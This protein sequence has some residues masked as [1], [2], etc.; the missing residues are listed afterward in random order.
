MVR[1]FAS[2]RSI[3][4]AKSIFVGNLPEYTTRHEVET[5]FQEYGSIVQTNIIKKSFSK[6]SSKL[7][8]LFFCA[9][10]NAESQ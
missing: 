4:D 7:L 2:P 3:M 5:L 6:S 10:T 1:G 9:C 8:Y